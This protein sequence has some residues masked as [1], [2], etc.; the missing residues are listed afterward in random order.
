[1]PS[2]IVRAQ[3]SGLELAIDFLERQRTQ[4]LAVGM[5]EEQHNGGFCA[6]CPQRGNFSRIGPLNTRKDAKGESKGFW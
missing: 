3:L 1:M 2:Q 5:D 4:L 6:A